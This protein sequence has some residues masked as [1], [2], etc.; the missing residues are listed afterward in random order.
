MESAG[1]PL[2]KQK[3]RFRQNQI[4]F[5]GHIIDA[6]GV[7]LDPGKVD[8]IAN[9]P[10]PQNAHELKRFLGLVNYLGKYLPNLATVGQPMYT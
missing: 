4:R 8:S 9:F 2:N 7:R 5:L 1:L 6:Q 10:V 3:C